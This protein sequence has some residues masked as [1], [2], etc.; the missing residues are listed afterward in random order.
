MIICVIL[1]GLCLT[2]KKTKRSNFAKFGKE[3]FFAGLYI[4]VKNEFFRKQFFLFDRS[5]LTRSAF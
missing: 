4:S 1:T 2:L 3:N 5:L